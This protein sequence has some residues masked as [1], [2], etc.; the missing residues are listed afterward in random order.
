MD[1]GFLLTIL[2]WLFLFIYRSIDND[3]FVK[4][5]PV[6]PRRPG[7]PRQQG[8]NQPKNE[9]R[10]RAAERGK[11]QQFLPSQKDAKGDINCL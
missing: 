11:R 8:S 9:E 7:F 2:S 3:H 1:W 10:P 4:G 5:R 6:D